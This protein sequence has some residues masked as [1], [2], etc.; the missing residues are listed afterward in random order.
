MRQT[1][2]IR[3]AIYTSRHLRRGSDGAYIDAKSADRAGFHKGSILNDASRLSRAQVAGAI[4]G[5]P[6][7]H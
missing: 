5:P 2:D 1:R 6:R 4:N 3:V 7:L